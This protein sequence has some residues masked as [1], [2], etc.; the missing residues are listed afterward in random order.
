MNTDDSRF[1][2]IG[3]PIPRKEDARL[4]TGAGRFSDDFHAPRQAY[5]AMVRSPHPHARIRGVDT[6]A[7]RAMPGVLGVFT[8]ADCLADGLKP[9]P[10]DPLPKTKYDMKLHAPGGGEAFFGPHLLLPVDK[11]RHVGEAVAMVVAQ[12]QTQALDAA[13][14]V[15]VDYEVLPFVLHSE[16]AMKPGAP[17]VWAEAPGNMPIDSA[18]GDAEATDRAFATADYVV[19][20]DF[21]IDRVTGVPLEPRSALAEYDAKSG[22]YT[23]HAGSGGAVRQKNEL[24]A[25]LGVALDRLRVLS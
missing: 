9:I 12:T 20:M 18:F 13:E 11:A 19:A 22:R 2:F 23:L 15:A 3:R 4:T 1:R 21:H 14:A 24:A 17:L 7:A 6:A 8:G 25:V 16:D 10:H 5:L